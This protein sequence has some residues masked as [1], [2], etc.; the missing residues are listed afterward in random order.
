MTGTC[1]ACG[2]TFRCFGAPKDHCHYCRQTKRRAA[3]REAQRRRRA[4]DALPPRACADC[5][6]DISH[7]GRR[8]AAADAGIAYGAPRDLALEARIDAHLA[9]IRATRRFSIV[10]VIWARPHDHVAAEAPDASGLW[11]SPITARKHRE[12]AA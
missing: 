1:L 11:R 5:G 7:R 3:W 9:H 12:G 4:G 10:D 8:C 2:R 6:V